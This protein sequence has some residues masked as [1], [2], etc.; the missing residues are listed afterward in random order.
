VG[1]DVEFSA[2]T[3]SLAAGERGLDLSTSVEL[4]R[5]RD[6]WTPPPSQPL[7]EAVWQAWVAKGRAQDRRT[8]ATRIRAVKWVSIA[9]LLAAAG[10]WSHVAP[11]EAML[12]FLVTAT[13][14][15]LIVQA[16]QSK[17][18]AVAVA[19][20]V[21]ALCY[22]PVVPAF[23]FS[24]D[25]HRAFVGASVVPFIVSLVWPNGRNKRVESN[26]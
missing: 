25:W 21:L 13:A 9:G 2:A 14:I 8:S 10:V 24:G 17:F 3:L 7:N 23:S 19:F 16:L 5:P 6:A 1:I 26:D 12:R 4:Q 20:G 15:V 22:N 18:Y 11:F